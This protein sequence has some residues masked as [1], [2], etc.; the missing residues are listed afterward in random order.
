MVV[1]LLSLGLALDHDML[2]V[3]DVS[4]LR[5][6]HLLRRGVRGRVLLRSKALPGK[7]LAP[8]LVGHGGLGGLGSGGVG[9][10]S[11]LVWVALLEGLLDG[12]GPVLGY[13]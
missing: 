9:V 2:L 3:V 12:L 13:G 1:V 8:S 7:S 10:A 4:I 6:L 11:F 5:E